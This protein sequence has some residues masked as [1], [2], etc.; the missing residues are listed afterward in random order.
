MSDDLAS[1]CDVTWAGLTLEALDNLPMLVARIGP[2]L[3]YTF[4]NA[5]YE[6]WFGRERA[7][8]VG[9][10]MRDVL[11]DAAWEVLE[12][13]AHLALSGQSVRF[14]TRA[15]YRDGGT[16]EI[17]AH[18][19]PDDRG[20]FYALVEDVSVLRNAERRAVRVL[21]GLPDPFL[22]LDAD[23][24]VLFANRAARDFAP[25][26]TEVGADFKAGLPAA[27]VARLRAV[28]RSGEPLEMET[29]ALT[30][31]DRVLQVRAF[32]LDEGLGLHAR[33]VT[34]RRAT[35]KALRDSERRLSIAAD[36]VLGVAY[37][38]DLATGHVHRSAGLEA[39]LGVAPAE[40]EPTA[41]WWRARVHPE[42]LK[43][44]QA[45][46]NGYASG[47]WHETEYRVRHADGRWIDVMDRANVLFDDSGRPSRV[48]GT[49]IDVTAIKQSEARLRVLIDELNHRVKNSLA[50]VL[51]I[52]ALSARD[53][54][55]VGAFLTR[56][57]ERLGAIARAHDLLTR[58]HWTDAT[59]AEVV[60]ASVGGYAEGDRLAASGPPV[61]LSPKQALALS[62]ALHE[63]V[64]NAVKHGALAAPSGRVDVDWRNDDREFE[65]RWREAG[66]ARV[67]SP[68]RQGFGSRLLASAARDLDGRIDLAYR[69]PGVEAVIAFPLRSAAPQ[70]HPSTY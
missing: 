35:E 32:L 31:P 67:R 19:V 13:R 44:A 41:D 34:E 10:S 3:R 37:E 54:P 18:Y 26:R 47:A 57:Q 55:D 69:S 53:C 64:V 68:R 7:D 2:D 12:P 17:V 33:D 23:L 22:V 16:R 65:L 61:V 27:D 6:R 52:A 21:E 11:G 62:L 5:A 24:C 25:A 20:G 59:A 43:A 49:T 15:P 42:D 39:L 56:F 38:W 63:L 36:A 8:L 45:V 66:G 70:A 29:R 51:S 60:E 48:I 28:L 14:E 9:R 4:V 46:A 30:Q 40:A 58:R 50:T 1:S